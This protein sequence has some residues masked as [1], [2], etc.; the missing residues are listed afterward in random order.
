MSELEGFRELRSGRQTIWRD[1]V[2]RTEKR[3]YCLQVD[4]VTAREGIA[5]DLCYQSQVSGVELDFPITPW[6]GS[7][8]G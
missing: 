6:T 7:L 1:K 3:L 2:I 4:E 8:V 5:E